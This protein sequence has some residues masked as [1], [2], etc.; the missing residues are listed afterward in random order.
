M[1]DHEPVIE[2]DVRYSGPDATAQA[3]AKGREHLEQAEV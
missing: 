3:W 1:A 2:V